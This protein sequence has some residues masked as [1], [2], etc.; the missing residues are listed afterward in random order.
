M[1]DTVELGRVF[2]R[3]LLCSPVNIIP[4]MLPTHSAYSSSALFNDVAFIRHHVVAK[5]AIKTRSHTK[6][7][8]KNEL[9]KE[10]HHQ[11]NTILYY[12]VDNS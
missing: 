9:R 5:W 6:R 8:T 1:V 11:E 4:P 2:L 7:R 10:R 12:L 3:A